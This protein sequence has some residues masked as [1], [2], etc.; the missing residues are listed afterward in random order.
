[1]LGGFIPETTQEEYED[2]E[3]QIAKMKK[4]LEK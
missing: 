2:L 1:M 4:E 3:I